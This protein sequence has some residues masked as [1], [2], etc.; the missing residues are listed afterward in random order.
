LATYR[1]VGAHRKRSVSLGK[2]SSKRVTIGIGVTCDRV[3]AI[4]VDGTDLH[5][6]GIVINVIT[7][8]GTAVGI[9]KVAR[10]VQIIV[11]L[12]GYHRMRQ[13]VIQRTNLVVIV[14]C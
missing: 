3:D 7:F 11:R 2:S 5:L 8:V 10:L 9:S 14:V 12:G 6:I 4:K 1:I 13:Q